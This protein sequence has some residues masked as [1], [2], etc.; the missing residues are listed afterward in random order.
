MHT[1]A[2]SEYYYLLDI[3]TVTNQP[4][5]T[6]AS[7][8][9]FA[10]SSL[11]LEVT[12]MIEQDKTD[13]EALERHNVMMRKIDNELYMKM[14]DRVHDIIEHLRYFIDDF[15]EAQRDLRELNSTIGPFDTEADIALDEMAINRYNDAMD[16]S[17]MQISYY[18][19]ELGYLF[20]TKIAEQHYRQD[21]MDI[22]YILDIHGIF[23]FEN[24]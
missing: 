19:H 2:S 4:N 10:L 16:S 24:C 9:A 21:V 11:P 8:M 6:R 20:C 22:K 1:G 23:V 18:A 15:F 3:Q 13:L 12:K 7:N 5:Q 17:L 14:G